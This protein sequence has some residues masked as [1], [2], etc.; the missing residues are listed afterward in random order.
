MR[1]A[2]VGLSLVLSTVVAAFPVFDDA[3]LASA[4]SCPDCDIVRDSPNIVGG[5]IEAWSRS[6]RPAQSGTEIP[7]KL[8]ISVDRVYKGSS[9]PSLA[10]L[11][12]HSLV[13]LRDPQRLDLPEV[14]LWT[15]GSGGCQAFWEDPLGK[16]I[17][18]GVDTADDGTAQVWGPQILF[19]GLNRPDES[20]T[21]VDHRL[22]ALGSPRPPLVGNTPPPAEQP[23]DWMFVSA[24]GGGCLLLTLVLVLAGPRRDRRR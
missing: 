12:D 6:G 15:G 22:L 7:I 21:P 2:V 14:L 20:S 17:I 9:E 23:D 24:I 19:L 11:D 4:C 5:V 3:P 18:L 10:L 13:N 8:Q 1:S 16:Y